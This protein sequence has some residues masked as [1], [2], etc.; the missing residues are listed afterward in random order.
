MLQVTLSL[1]I[2]TGAIE[3]LLGSSEKRPYLKHDKAAEQLGAIR[4]DEI[5]L[6]LPGTY[7]AMEAVGFALVEARD[8][9]NSIPR[10]WDDDDEDDDFGDK[11]MGGL[12]WVNQPGA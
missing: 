3:E 2:C 8:D 6:L 7:P 1:R 5:P 4:K 12:A 10:S 11:D 9:Y